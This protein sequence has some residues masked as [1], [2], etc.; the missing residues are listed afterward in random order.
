MDTANG[1][2]TTSILSIAYG[3]GRFIAAGDSGFVRSSLNGQTWNTITGWQLSTI[4]DGGAVVAMMFDG[5]RFV[6]FARNPG[7]WPASG[8]H[9]WSATG[10]E[11]WTWIGNQLDGANRNVLNGAV[12]GAG[13]FVVALANEGFIPRFSALPPNWLWSEHQVGAANIRAVGYGHGRFVAVGANGMAGISVNQGASWTPLANP[14]G[15]GEITAAY[16]M[17]NG[18]VILAGPG[19]FAVVT[20]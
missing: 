15:T 19:R 13:T 3:N 9:A 4:L 6:A 2:G 20:P 1:F 12:S 18:N 17:E 11:N 5:Q 7:N 14:F 10:T 8:Q 16:G